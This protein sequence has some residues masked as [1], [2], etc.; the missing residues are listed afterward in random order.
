MEELTKSKTNAGQDVGPRPAFATRRSLLRSRSTPE[1]DSHHLYSPQFMDDH[2]AHHY[3]PDSCVPSDES[4]LNEFQSPIDE[5]ETE[6]GSDYGEGE[7]E[8]VEVR[9]GVL[10]LHDLE[11]RRTRQSRLARTRSNRSIKDPHLVSWEG[12]DDPM[13]PKNWPYSRKWAAT[14]IVSCFTFISPV[15]SSMVAP[16]LPA[17]AK[18]LDISSEVEQSLILSIFVLAYAVGPLFLGPLSE[19]YGRVIILQVANLFYLVFNIACGFVTTKGQLIAFRFLAGLGGSA[20][21]A[22]GGGVLSDCWRAEE[23]GK[24]ISIYSLAPLLGPAVGK[25]RFSPCISMIS[26]SF[27]QDPS[28]AVSSRR[29]VLGDGASGLLASSMPLSKSWASSRCAKPMHQ[30]CLH[31]KP[32]PCA[33]RPGIKLSTQSG[34]PLNGH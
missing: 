16:A 30:P 24:A 34:K 32:R 8:D 14:I 4:T 1:Y 19:I 23:R 17:M 6:K 5:A 15:S 10:D 7:E 25:L 22:L 3:H 20:P 29:R 18:S 28:R 27:V 2:G 21:L 33:R 11:S 31:A 13:S 26:D 9:D 12:E